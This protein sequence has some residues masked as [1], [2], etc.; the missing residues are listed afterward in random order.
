M[1]PRKKTFDE[2]NRILQSTH[3]IQLEKRARS[4][5]SPVISSFTQKKSDNSE[6]KRMK[7]KETKLE[8]TLKEM[9]KNNK[10]LLNEARAKQQLE[11]ELE[12]KKSDE[13]ELKILI[14]ACEAELKAK[15]ER[16]A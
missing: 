3:K 11:N 8:K 12:N 7:Q 4:Q 15:E 9:M 1:E 2:R 14:E 6:I 10:A 5:I 16:Q 13:K